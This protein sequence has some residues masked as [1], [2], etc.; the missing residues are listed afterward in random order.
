M[1]FNLSCKLYSHNWE[2]FISSPDLNF[3]VHGKCL[4]CGQ[5]ANAN[6]KDWIAVEY[7][8][9]P[10]ISIVINKL[11]LDD[12]RTISSLD[13][14]RSIFKVLCHFTSINGITPHDEYDLNKRLKLLVL[15]NHR[16]EIEKIAYFNWID[17]QDSSKEKYYWLL[18]ENEVYSNLCK[19]YKYNPN[20]SIS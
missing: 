15:K 3:W 4:K 13:E 12:S 1:K 9:I 5:A 7:F 20:R 19:Q 14:E 17:N 6:Y 16:S 18:A 11:S 2:W 10:E 8:E